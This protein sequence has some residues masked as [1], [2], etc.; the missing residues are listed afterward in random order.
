[1]DTKQQIF[2][3]MATAK[4]Q[5][6]TIETL[7]RELEKKLKEL[8]EERGRLEK[9]MEEAADKVL[10]PAVEGAVNRMDRAGQ[11]FELKFIVW[12]QLSGAVTGGLIF[13]ILKLFY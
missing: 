6:E 8:K 13:A 2:G 10:R 11:N 4:K 1:M 5:Q 7:I 9:V 12:T 3:L